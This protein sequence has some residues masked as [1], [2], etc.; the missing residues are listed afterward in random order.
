MGLGGLPGGWPKLKKGDVRWEP[1]EPNEFLNPRPGR[2]FIS[3]TLRR[4]SA[5]WPLL[6]GWK[7]ANLCKAGSSKITVYFQREMAVCPS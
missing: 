6:A 7:M 3:R 1:A 4:V 5:A 2:R